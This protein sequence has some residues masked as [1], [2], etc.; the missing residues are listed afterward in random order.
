[1]GG[2]VLKLGIRGKIWLLAGLMVVGLCVQAAHGLL[3]MRHSMTD[4]RR[5]A[6]RQTVDAASAIVTGFHARA[7]KGE[8]S[9]ADAKARAIEALR[10]MR[11]GAKKDYIFI[12]TLDNVAVLQP[13]R[14]ETEGT[15]QSQL[16]DANG[17]FTVQALS[18]V[19]SRD[20]AGYVN[21]FIRRVADAPPVPKLSHIQAFKP[22]N[23]MIGTGVYID[24]LDAA[25]QAMAWDAGL[26]GLA[27]LV[28]ATALGVLIAR[29]ITKPLGLLVLRMGALAK[30]ETHEAVSGTERHDE[31]GELARAMEIFR[32]NSIENHRLLDEQ[33]ALKHAA[34]EERGRAL[35]DMAA[36]LEKRLHHSVQS[37]TQVGE[38]LN[39]ASSAMNRTAEQAAQQTSAVVLAT[40]E[41]SVNVQTVATAAEELS[42]SGGEISRQVALTADIARN[43][44]EEAEQS[45]A[46]VAS[47][48]ATAGRIGEVVGLINDIAGQTNL[49]A[50]NATIEAA[51]AGEA[52]KGFAVVANEVKTLASQTAKA[53]QEITT[54]INAVQTE[55]NRAVAAIRHIGETINRVDEATS[56]IAGAVEEQNAAIQEITRSVQEAARGTSQ[57]SEHIGRVSEGTSTSRHAAQEVADSTQEMIAHNGELT[58]EIANFLDE[59]RAQAT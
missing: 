33:V 26:S 19:A 52:G 40:E 36:G 1:M 35:R 13:L 28:A 23:W 59:I 39:A 38:R 3:S 41:T 42:A 51:R 6:L 47:L 22:W 54:Q 2:T 57:V 44:A 14:P 53:T 56:S 58:Q 24:D 49:L 4:D 8:M 27:A 7:A 43:A 32:S 30:G 21:Y 46:M 10:M 37:M 9:E 29:S 45:N 12:Y 20:G 50:L 25:F 48:S 16:K 5:E 18:E 55:T 31:M 15:N 11:Y 17:L 34:S